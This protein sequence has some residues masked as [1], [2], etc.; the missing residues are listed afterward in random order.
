MGDSSQVVDL[1]CGSGLITRVLLS[2]LGPNGSIVG[3]DLC[4]GMLA[5]AKSTVQDARV[6]WH[7]AEATDLPLA[8]E[9]VDIVC[10]HQGLQFFSDQHAAVR[11][12]HRVLR[13]GGRVV[14][15]VWGAL[16]DNPEV[17]AM[18]S[19][20]GEFLGQDVGDAMTGPCRFPDRNERRSVL[21]EGDF[22]GIEV[23][24]VSKTAHHP[25]VRIAMDGQLAALPIAATIDALGPERR[26]ELLDRICELLKPYTDDTGALSVPACSNLAVA[27]KQTGGV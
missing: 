17:A 21:H 7:E 11:E 9:T 10:C 25:N 3:I 24:T 13:P 18:A 1:A 16:G 4:P 14:I 15:G 23:E 19:A 6:A 5:H 2:Q 27:T 26:A 22:V 8:D 12:I 20:I